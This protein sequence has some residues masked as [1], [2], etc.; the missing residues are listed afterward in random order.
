M[1]RSSAGRRLKF[2]RGCLIAED[3]MKMTKG[4]HGKQRYQDDVRNQ[5]VEVRS[6]RNGEK[7]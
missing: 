7:G 3:D 1:R 2:L 5:A 4:S 6:M